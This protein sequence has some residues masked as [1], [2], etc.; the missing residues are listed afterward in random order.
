MIAGSLGEVPDAIK[1]N[2]RASAQSAFQQMNLVTRE[3][4]EVQKAVLQRTRAKLDALERLIAQLET[5]QP[6]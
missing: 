6:K 2:I 5:D 4:F 1:E 3:E